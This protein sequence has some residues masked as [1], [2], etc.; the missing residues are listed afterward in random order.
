M[1]SSVCQERSLGLAHIEGEGIILIPE[2]GVILEAPT[3]SAK[4][5]SKRALRWREFQ[6]EEI[7]GEAREM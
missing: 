1:L 6:M 3:T 5:Y 7:L 2:A 4:A